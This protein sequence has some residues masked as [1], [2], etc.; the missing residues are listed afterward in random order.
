MGLREEIENAVAIKHKI[1]PHHKGVHRVE[2]NERHPNPHVQPESTEQSRKDYTIRAVVEDFHARAEARARRRLE[3]EPVDIA[4]HKAFITTPSKVASGG[5]RIH[6]CAYDSRGAV[7][8]MASADD[9]AYDLPIYIVNP[10]LLVADPAGDVEM[11]VGQDELGNP[12]TETYREDPTQA[13]IEI[14]ADLRQEGG[15]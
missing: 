5:V 10:P 6:K 12:I 7:E 2:L 3:E 11:V 9:F 8:V 15:A 14:L 4:E 13:M 1:D